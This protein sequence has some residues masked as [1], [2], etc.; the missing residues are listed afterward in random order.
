M[1]ESKSTQFHGS[2][3]YPNGDL[4]NSVISSWKENLYSMTMQQTVIP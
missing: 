2:S 1:K 4:M 3:K